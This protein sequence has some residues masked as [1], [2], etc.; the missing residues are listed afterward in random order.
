MPRPVGPRLRRRRALATGALAA[1]VTLSIAPGAGAAPS[2]SIS[3]SIPQDPEQ[4]RDYWT[5]ERMRKADPLEA[6]TGK[7]ATKSATPTPRAATPDQELPEGLEMTYPY[8]I[9]GR[10]FLH[11]EGDDASCSATVVT[12]FTRN[13]I[14]TAGHCVVD[15]GVSGPVWASNLLFVPAYRNGSHPFGVYPGNSSGAPA[16]WAFEGGLAFDIGVVNLAPGAG[17]LIQ[18]QLGS[19]GIAFNRA[20]KSYRGKTFQLFGY[21]ASPPGIYD[22]ERPIICNSQFRGIEAF[23]GA[24]VTSPCHQQE[25]ASGGGW[26]MSGGIVNSVTSHSGCFNPSAACDLVS[27]TYLGNAALKLWSAAAG[28]LPKGRKKQ[29]RHCKHLR[30]KPRQRCINKAETFAPVVRP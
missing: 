2:G 7:A 27:G 15:P 16:I 23:S 30:P 20:P 1:A 5:P 9:H 24:L 10:L 11:I 17:G 22:G 18:D 26:V 14:L 28:G 21:P 8:R 13:L 6:P 3:H 25:G 12:S 29:I 4:V 19:R